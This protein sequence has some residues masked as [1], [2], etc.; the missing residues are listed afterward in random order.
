MENNWREKQNHYCNIGWRPQ[1]LLL[2]VLLPCCSAEMAG[3]VVNAI[4][5]PASHP[6]P[7][8]R[9]A[10]WDGMASSRGPA[11]CQAVEE[12]DRCKWASRERERESVKMSHQNHTYSNQFFRRH[13]HSFDIFF[14]WLFV[15]LIVSARDRVLDWASAKQV[16][17]TGR[18]IL[19]KIPFRRFL[20]ER[21]KIYY[22]TCRKTAVSQ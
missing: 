17:Q 4:P 19:Q 10:G 13:I 11:P 20:P 18:R 9:R 3:A 22:I 21:Q 14:F 8:Q 1:E 7:V 12:R 2:H 15:F 6:L 16:W 5:I